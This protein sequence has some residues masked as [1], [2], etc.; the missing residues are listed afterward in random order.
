M[1]NRQ[2]PMINCQRST[3]P[4]CQLTIAHYP[5]T[6]LRPPHS[7]LPNIRCHLPPPRKTPHPRAWPH[8]P[9]HQT[10]TTRANTHSHKNSS[11][12]TMNGLLDVQ[13]TFAL[14]SKLNGWRKKRRDAEEGEWHVQENGHSPFKKTAPQRGH[15]Q[16]P[17]RRPAHNGA[18]VIL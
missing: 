14:P 18:V 16:S 2:L 5:L 10:K 15:G 9:T 17:K 12:F 8:P 4:H 13:T 11:P 3:S 7:L 1:A 6:I